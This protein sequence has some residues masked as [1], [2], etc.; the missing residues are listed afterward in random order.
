MKTLYQ[1]IFLVLLVTMAGCSTPQSRYEEGSYTEVESQ[2]D[3][4]T[5]SYEPVVGAD[6]EFI[7]EENGG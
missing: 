5:Y 1:T 3:G 6:E 2:T 4:R 7:E